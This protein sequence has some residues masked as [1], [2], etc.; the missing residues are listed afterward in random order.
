[1]LGEVGAEIWK[2]IFG[3]RQMGKSRM[4]AR[5][6][7]IEDDKK[8][9]DRQER[10]AHATHVLTLCCAP[11]SIH[12]KPL[13]QWLSTA[14]PRTQDTNGLRDKGLLVLTLSDLSV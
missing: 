13:R 8:R 6:K 1:M 7:R 5:R 4:S 9:R 3:A 2:N 10:G 11:I 12:M 14:V